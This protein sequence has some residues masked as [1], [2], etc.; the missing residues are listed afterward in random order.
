[1]YRFSFEEEVSTAYAIII[2]DEGSH[3]LRVLG[4]YSKTSVESFTVF[5]DL[6]SVVLFPFS[7]YFRLTVLV[8]FRC[9]LGGS[10]LLNEVKTVSDVRSLFSL[11]SLTSGDHTWTVPL[12]THEHRKL[13]RSLSVSRTQNRG[14]SEISRNN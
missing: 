1:M 12:Y 4:F 14:R 7:F 3:K 6:V 9:T 13:S 11:Y 2:T 10:G 5:L 8:T